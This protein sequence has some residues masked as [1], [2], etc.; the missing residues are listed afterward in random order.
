[1]KT[2][3][4]HALPLALALLVATGACRKLDQVPE[5]ADGAAAWLY[6]HQPDGEADEV[7]EAITYLVDGLELDA[8]EG[9]LEGLV[10]QLPAAAVSAVGRTA[11]E[12]LPA[13]EQ[14]AVT[15][16]QIEEGTYVRLAEHQGM[17]IASVIP[18]SVQDVVNTHV[19][20]DQDEIHGGYDAYD[21]Q[22]TTDGDAFT[23]GQADDLAWSTDYTVSVLGNTYDANIQGQIRWVDLDDGTRVGLGRAY[24]P[25]PGTFTKGG[26]YFRQDYHLDLFFERAPGETIHLFGVWRDLR[27]AGIHSSNAAFIATTS[28][29][30]AEADETIAARCS[31][32]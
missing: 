12:S 28:K 13:D 16:S 32:G 15:D 23:A 2:T 27:V 20:R 29:R 6:Q 5:D 8:L 1:M 11:V 14:A 17:V 3:P 24:L 4:T 31:G 10:A 19:R 18:C 21:R 25:A 9:S 26:G 30:F 22:W 7:A